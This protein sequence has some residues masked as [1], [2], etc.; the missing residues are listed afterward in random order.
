MS[1]RGI[2]LKIPTL[3]PIP[4]VRFSPGSQLED[5]VLVRS[6][7]KALTSLLVS[8]RLLILEKISILIFKSG[9]TLILEYKTL[10]SVVLGFIRALPK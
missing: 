5:S 9:I 8:H 4:E 1:Y 6:L 7:I 10:G 2:N 3:H